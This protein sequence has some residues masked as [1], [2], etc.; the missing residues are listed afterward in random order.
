MTH[1]PGRFGPLDGWH[2]GIIGEVVSI[3]VRYSARHWSFCPLFEAKIAAE[4]AGFRLVEEVSGDTWGP[5]SPSSASSS[6]SVD[7]SPHVRT[8][9][10][11]AKAASASRT[12]R[13][14]AIE[15][16]SSWSIGSSKVTGSLLP[17]G[18]H[19]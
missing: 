16:A 18:F 2:P 1:E 6:A 5:A 14:R 13:E 3:Q 11:A 19:T 15:E 9:M 17:C 8:A 10:T 7:A 4:Q 12:A